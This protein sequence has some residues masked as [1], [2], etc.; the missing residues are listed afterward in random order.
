MY[1]YLFHQDRLV[2]SL[3]NDISPFPGGDSNCIWSVSESSIS[4]D[5]LGALTK[6]DSDASFSVEDKFD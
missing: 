1:I 5:M 4:V 6:I 2:A 3:M